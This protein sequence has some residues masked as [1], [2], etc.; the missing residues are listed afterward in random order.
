MRTF[1]IFE[2][3]LSA[4]EDG[5][6]R[7]A[8]PADKNKRCDE[9]C[10]HYERPNYCNLWDFKCN[11]EYVCDKWKHQGVDHAIRNFDG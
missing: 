9:G 10:A 1:R 7:E 6:Y 2:T 8:V 5:N 4:V 11:P 3:E